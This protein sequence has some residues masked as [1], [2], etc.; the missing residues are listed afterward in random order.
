VAVSAALASAGGVIFGLLEQWPVWGVGVAG[1][2]PWLPV[3]V[4]ETRWLSRLH[5]PL[6]LF[7]VL[8]V[9]QT[10]H[11]L[12]HVVQMTQIHILRLG[13]VEARGVFGALDV[14]WVH[15]LWNTWVLATV[16]LLLRSFRNNR[17]LWV[18][19]WLA[20]WHEAEHVVVFSTYLLTGQAGTPGLLGQGGLVAGGLP[21]RRSDLHF[22]YNLIE[23]AFLVGAFLWQFPRFGKGVAGTGAGRA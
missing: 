3:L 13:G 17:W 8:V 7:Y 5:G 18:T 1:L 10:A 12:E 19:A 2:V 23:T 15:F 11:L 20:V 4:S 21:L 6:A 16:L 22:L 14:E 9:T